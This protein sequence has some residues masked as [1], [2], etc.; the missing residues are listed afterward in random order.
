[1]RLALA[2]GLALLVGAASANAA[3]IAF[4]N[5]NNSTNVTGVSTD[6]W[7]INPFGTSSAKTDY[8]KDTG[9]GAGRISV[10]GTGTAAGNL[11]GNNG[12]FPTPNANNNFGSY[13][14]ATLNDIG[15]PQVAGS[16]LSMTGSDNNGRS[17][18]IKLD[19]KLSGVTLSYAT[20]GTSTGYATHTID[21][22]TDGGATWAALESHAANKTSTWAVHTVNVGNIFQ[23]TYG[24]DKNII[25]ISVAGATSTNGNNRFDNILVTGTIVPEPATMSLLGLAGLA[26]LRRRK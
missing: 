12:D 4:W 22:S 15:V 8:S 5:F 26:M 24:F 6:L 2:I 14:G 21:Y 1:M 3:N 20:R 18:L 19:D 11:S 9:D 10:W 25:R 7:R 17:F 23:S 16:S 13:T